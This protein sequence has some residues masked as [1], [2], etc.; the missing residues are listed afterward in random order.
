VRIDVK[1]APIHLAGIAGAH[2]IR[3]MYIQATKH[4]ASQFNVDLDYFWSGNY[5]LPDDIDEDITVDT[6][7]PAGLEVCPR[8][9]KLQAIAMRIHEPVGVVNMQNV[10]IHSLTFLAGVRKGIIKRSDAMRGRT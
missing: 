6:T 2:R 10:T 1:T 9:Q 4:N 8:H 7:T 5:D 3:R